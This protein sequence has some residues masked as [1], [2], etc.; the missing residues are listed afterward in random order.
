M[1]GILCIGP[2]GLGTYLVG[3]TLYLF[4]VGTCFALYSALIFDL[5]GAAGHSGSGRFAICNSLGNIPP[6][7]MT[8]VD[9][10]GYHFFGPR[11]LPGTEAVLGVI[12]ATAFLAWLFLKKP[13]TVSDSQPQ[14]V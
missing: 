6:L 12:A 11:G 9:G 10:R 4:T 1:V 3:A 14:P 13:R 7:Y 8:W 5:M 2:T